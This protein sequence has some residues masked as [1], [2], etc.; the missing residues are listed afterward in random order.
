MEK[1]RK[2]SEDRRIWIWISVSGNALAPALY[3]IIY[4]SVCDID[5]KACLWAEYVWP[6]QLPVITIF[7][8]GGRI[9][10]DCRKKFIQNF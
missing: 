6:C 9:S 7:V 3:P 1:Q 8:G 4:F 10:A 5:E 2:E